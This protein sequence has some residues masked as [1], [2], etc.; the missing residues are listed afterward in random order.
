MLPSTEKTFF[1][2]DVYKNLVKEQMSLNA[3]DIPRTGGNSKMKAPLL[4]AGSYPARLV[5][6]IGLGLQKQDPYQGQEKSPKY[7]ILTTYEL[8]DEFMLDENEE[9]LEDKPRWFSETIPMHSLDADLAKS[10]KRYMAL[11]PLMKYNGDWAK[12]AGLPVTLA[13]GTAKKRDGTDRNKILSTTTMRP[14]EADK[15]P[16]LVN[17]PKVFDLEEPDADLF[18]S[19]PAW[20]QDRMKEN[21]NYGGSALEKLVQAGR[22]S[23]GTETKEEPKAP[24]KAAQRVSEP[25]EEDEEDSNEADW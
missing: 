17:E 24:K 4:A 2:R 1:I 16:D 15:A 12:L 19:F 13:I 22:T 9:V 3:R 23:S 21:L 18:W 5:Q 25:V 14:K 6:V 20:I 8:L 7:E 10:T 11:D